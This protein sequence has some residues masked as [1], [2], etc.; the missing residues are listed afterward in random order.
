MHIP[1]NLQHFPEAT[2]IVL[3][4]E[5]HARLLIADGDTLEP[6]DELKHPRTQMSDS[7]G[8]FAS[9]EGTH[10]GSGLSDK[11]DTPRKKAFAADIAKQI[12]QLIQNGRAE[13]IRLVS[14]PEMLHLIEKKLPDE[15]QERIASR[16]EK[17]LMKESDV[18][19]LS[20]IFELPEG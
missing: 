16:L 5:E 19:V 8:S 7:E 3:T 9:S 20:R 10:V 1:E 15:T 13:R 12:A 6:V 17:N 2:L 11:H 4:D 18:D 14:P